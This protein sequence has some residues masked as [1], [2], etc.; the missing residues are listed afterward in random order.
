MKQ[1]RLMLTIVLVA[2]ISNLLPQI[3]DGGWLGWAVTVP[4]TILHELAHYVYALI[5]NGRP[6]SFSIFPTVVDGGKMDSY[7]H[8]T[9]MPNFWNAATVVMAPIL[10]IPASVFLMVFGSSRS[11]LVN[12]LC[13]W[14]AS[15]GFYSAE[16]S[17]ADWSI[18]FA[19]PLSFV[20]A[21]PILLFSIWVWYKLILIQL[22]RT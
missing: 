15:V 19:Y 11:P 5:L 10:A 18:A 4:G 21:V 20:F 2:W 6:G 12:F 9:F 3:F 16:P 8:I 22:R 1:L 14:A 17:R 7:G 13:I